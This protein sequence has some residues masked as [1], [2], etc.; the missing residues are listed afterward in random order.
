VTDALDFTVTLA[1]AARTINQ[2][3]SMDETLAVIAETA[4]NSIPG[5]D[6]VGIS[7]MHS[8][9]KVE[10][11]AATGDLV[12]ELDALQYDLDQGPCVSS[13]REESVIVVEHLRHAQRWPQYVPQ[14]LKLG[15][16]SQ[17]ALRLYV[18]E[19]GTMGGINLYSTS[20]ED[21]EPHAPHM[22]QVFAAQAAVAL[23]HAQE[24]DQLQQALESRQAIGQAV[25]IIIE[26]YKLD[27]HAAFNFI[28]RL[29]Q[30]SNTKLRDIAARVVAD[31]IATGQ[32]DK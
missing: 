4:R 30:H 2:P 15:L 1:E 7:L 26:R 24:L 25:G 21:V 32:Q 23:G 13:L 18:D 14:A 28:A 20:T 3:R 31:A 10:T 12:W 19:H 29:S 27:E 6:D 8:D 11:K 22:A 5:F 9:G 16:K 17:M